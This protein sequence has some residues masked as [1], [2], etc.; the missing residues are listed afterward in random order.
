MKEKVI[1]FGLGQDFHRFINSVE[2]KYDVVGYTDSEVDK[3][4]SH[5]ELTPVFSVQEAIQQKDVAFCAKTGDTVNSIK[6]KHNF[7]I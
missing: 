1:V 5:T 7:F 3:C 6:I 4:K 2:N